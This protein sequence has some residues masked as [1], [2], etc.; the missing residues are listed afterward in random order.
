MFGVKLKHLKK[1]G[2]IIFNCFDEAFL[3]VR[4]KPESIVAAAG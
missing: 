2:D 1:A 4:F 3:R